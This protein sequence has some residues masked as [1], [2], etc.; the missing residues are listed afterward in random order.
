MIG[1]ARL[2]VPDWMSLNG[3]DLTQYLPDGR[4]IPRADADMMQMNGSCRVDQHVSPALEDVPFRF[5]QLP[6][7]GDLLPIS[8]PRPWTPYIPEGGGEHAIIP[9]RF[10]RVIDQ[11]GP[12]KRRIF[13]IAAR[14]EAGLE[15]NHHD[16]YVPI[17]EF[18]LMITQLR[19]VRPAR[20]SAEVAMEHH[21]EPTA[22]VVFEQVVFPVD[23]PKFERYG[24]FSHKII[25]RFLP[26]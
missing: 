25:H 20:E 3:M 13:D 7:L 4:T 11:K 15:R 2:D 1:D 19:D 14:K 17:V 24:R 10:T 6:P 23:V 5:F 16:P 9:V 8:P 12:G 18:L 22:P 21:Q 26:F